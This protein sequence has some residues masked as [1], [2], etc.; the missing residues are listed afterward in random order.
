LEEKK[1]KKKKTTVLDQTT[2]LPGI[3]INNSIGRAETNDSDMKLEGIFLRYF[4]KSTVQRSG[5]ILICYNEL[6]N[7]IEWRTVEL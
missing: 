2:Q 7:G 5:R 6:R 4:E 3:D 1:K